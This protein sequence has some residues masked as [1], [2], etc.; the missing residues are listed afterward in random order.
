MTTRT[1]D[2]SQLV[3]ARIAGALYILTIVIGMVSVI[4]VGSRLIVPGNDDMT[5]QNIMT[6]EL[7]FRSGIVATL[8]M[9][10]GVLGLSA[11]LYVVL[12]KVNRGLA[13][14]AMLMRSAEA[15]VGTATALFGLT[16]L[17]LVN[18]ERHSTVID[19]QQL[20]AMVGVALDVQ[21][22]GLDLVLFL[23]GLGGTVFGYLFFVSGYV[24]RVLAA[25]GIFS[26]LS[27]LV[28]SLFGILLTES[29][30]IL[31]TVLY[32]IGGAFELVFGFWLVFKGVDLTRDLNRLDRESA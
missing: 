23:V 20:N 22:A 3:Y 12:E 9:Y 14:L 1:A 27:I 26:Y 28:L 7:L 4:L 25:W 31:E 32:A 29:P 5:T 17:V 6:N 18:G 2:S 24:P 10:A 30:V 15:I 8:V 19:T 16:A 11:A 21:A 13:L